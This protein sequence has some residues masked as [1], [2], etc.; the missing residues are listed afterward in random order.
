ML[1]AF[2]WA[3]LATLTL[4]WGY[5]RMFETKDRTFGEMD[6]MVSS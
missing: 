6:Y 4:A 5:F 1:Q 3:G 2:F